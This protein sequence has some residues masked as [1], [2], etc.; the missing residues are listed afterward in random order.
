MET[1]TAE[2]G[3]HCAVCLELDVIGRLHG[4]L[5]ETRKAKYFR[6]EFLVSTFEEHLNEFD[7]LRNGGHKLEACFTRGNCGEEPRPSYGSCRICS[8]ID[9]KG[10]DYQYYWLS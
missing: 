3:F 8:G 9:R 5:M 7:A 2:W 6:R 1:R 4:S 10:T